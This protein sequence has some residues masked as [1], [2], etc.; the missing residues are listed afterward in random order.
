MLCG[1]CLLDLA[2]AKQ[3]VGTEESSVRDC[4]CVYRV[5][6]CKRNAQYCTPCVVAS[7]VLSTTI[8][9]CIETYLLFPVERPPID[10]RSK[11]KGGK[12]QRYFEYV[13][14]SLHNQ[15]FL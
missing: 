7:A 11:P 12:F 3:L 13:S 2:A 14:A 4:T 9:P 6:V 15:V 1:K 10:A 8:Q 5:G